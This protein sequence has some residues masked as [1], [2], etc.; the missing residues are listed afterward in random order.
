M[1]SMCPRIRLLLLHALTHYRRVVIVVVLDPFSNH[2][3]LFL[4]QLERQ[5]YLIGWHWRTQV[6]TTAV[7]PVYHCLI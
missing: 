7:A 5:Q 1:V 2:W 4:H 3:F 6:P